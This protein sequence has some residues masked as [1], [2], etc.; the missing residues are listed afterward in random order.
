LKIHKHAVRV[1]GAG[2]AVAA[3]LAMSACAAASDGTPSG[4]PS[5]ATTSSAPIADPGAALTSA[6]GKFSGV[7]YDLKV[8]SGEGINGTGSHS[9]TVNAKGTVQGVSVEIAAIEIGADLYAKVNLGAL[10]ATVGL[11]PTKWYQLDPTAG[12]TAVPFTVTLDSLG[13]IAELKIDAGAGHEA[14]SEDFQFSNYGSPSPITKPD[15]AIPAPDGIYQ[16]LNG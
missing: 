7:G 3:A 4:N 1:L 5:G 14:D 8:T 15:G 12:E 11:D 10:T 9:A 16:V 2:L 6:I 13:R